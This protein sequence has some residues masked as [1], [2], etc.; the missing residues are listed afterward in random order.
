MPIYIKISDINLGSFRASDKSTLLV[1]CGTSSQMTANHRSFPTVQ[2]NEERTWEL[3]LPPL[4]ESE[5]HIAI[6][7]R[8]LLKQDKEVG[9]ITLNLKTLPKDKVVHHMVSLL[10][11]KDITD[12]PYLI[13]AV[14]V[15]TNGSTKPFE[16]EEVEFTESF[17]IEKDKTF[18]E[19]G[20]DLTYFAMGRVLV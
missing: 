15:D 7:K 10:S 17:V 14:H 20:T 12:P 16:A 5:L 6:F 2:R 19:S 4:N 8:R 18:E 3:D 1:Y 13:L 11:T 9:Q